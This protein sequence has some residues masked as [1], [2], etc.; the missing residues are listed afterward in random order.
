M[1]PVSAIVS[2]S[3]VMFG[4]LYFCWCHSKICVYISVSFSDLCLYVYDIATFACS[5]LCFVSDACIH[6]GVVFGFVYSC[7]CYCSF[8]YSY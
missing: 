8:V 6:V 3:G 5:Y 7:W 1:I 2:L 4:L